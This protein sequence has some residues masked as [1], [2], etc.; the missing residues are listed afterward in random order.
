MTRKPKPIPVNE[1]TQPTGWYWCIA[2]G[3]WRHPVCCG[4]HREAKSRTDCSSKC[5]RREAHEKAD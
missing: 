4:I 5:E 1:Q 3:G 2:I